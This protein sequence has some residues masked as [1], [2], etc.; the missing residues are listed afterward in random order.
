VTIL[1]LSWLALSAVWLYVWVRQFGTAF[2][3]R[4]PLPA[5]TPGTVK[6][7]AVLIASAFLIPAVVAVGRLFLVPV[8]LAYILKTVADAFL[9]AGLAI[10]V[11]TILVSS[12]AIYWIAIMFLIPIFWIYSIGVLWFGILNPGKSHVA[13]WSG[14]VVWGALSVASCLLLTPSSWRFF[15]S[16]YKAAMTPATGPG[17][18]SPNQR[19][20]PAAGAR[21]PG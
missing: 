18:A 3:D 15:V 13:T 16:R 14:S 20:N 11:A 8:T 4:V 6:A 1:E 21:L 19:I 9:N 12:R 2:R 5:D 10:G 7:A 17:G